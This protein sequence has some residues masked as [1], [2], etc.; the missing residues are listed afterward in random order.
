MGGSIF[1]AAP[2]CKRRAAAL[3]SNPMGTGDHDTVRDET[4]EDVATG[5]DDV[6]TRVDVP[7]AMT[8][9]P[10]LESPQEASPQ[11]ASDTEPDA[12][13]PIDAEET[14]PTAA[15]IALVRSH[16]T[17]TG[18]SQTS[19]TTLRDTLTVRDVERTRAF[20]KTAL[21]VASVVLLP[22]P[23]LGGDP[24]LKALF[25]G[26]LL[27][28]GAACLLLLF[29]LRDPTNY[30]LSK[31][32]IVGYVCMTGAFGGILYF[33][34]F[35][36][37]PVIIPFGLYFFGLGH[38]FRGTFYVYLWCSALYLIFALPL[39]LGWVADGGLIAPAALGAAEAL[40]IIGAVEMV[41]LATYLSSRMSRSATET[42]L[43]KHDKAVRTIAGRDALLAEARMDLD[44]LLRAR[45]LGRFTDEVIGGYQLG[46]ILGRGGMGEV[47]DAVH[48][49]S[50][51]PAAVKLLH[52]HFLSEPQSLER[53]FRECKVAS[54]L[55]VPNV[56]K[57]FT[58][59]NT[60]DPIPYIAMERLYGHDLSDY[61]RARERMRMS[62]VLRLL[63]QV[64]RGLEAAR[65]AGIVHRD[66]KPR[67]LFRD[68]G[69]DKDRNTW[70]I[71]DFGISKLAGDATLTVEQV[72]GTPS[73]MAPEQ[74][75]GDEVSHRTDLYA[76]AIVAY[77]ALT[78]R[79]AFSGDSAQAIL[80]QVVNDMPPPPSEMYGKLHGDVDS[81]LAIA[82]AKDPWERFDSGAE[83]ADALEKANRGRL[84][85]A[86]R[87][88]AQRILDEHPWR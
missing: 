1:L 66:L 43:Q 51:E 65:E 4:R 23:W 11:E 39:G 53:F 80:Y 62:E 58:T 46:Q 55:E 38:K 69:P 36:P 30:R 50:E 70:K 21:V 82:L 25:I 3:S 33:G 35:S 5:A 52:A 32:L 54:K 61:L 75:S 47:Y 87:E 18:G 67:N 42:A 83:L 22:L 20:L 76:L 34:P 15:P 37:A 60:D 85:G 44:K 41:F 28:S 77:R 8:S 88:R 48:V 81:V 24:L 14:A 68:E 64:G 13:E 2:G 86:L 9:G 84:P 26:S 79:P 19:V 73:Y 6:A 72:V 12:L 63:R 56:V 71:L 59:S 16:D 49:D 74:A 7:K 57:V 17:A 27:V 40:S 31:L 45:G 29:H 10:T 78:G